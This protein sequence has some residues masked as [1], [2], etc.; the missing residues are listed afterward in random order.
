MGGAI[1]DEAKWRNATDTVKDAQ[2]AWL[3]L[4]PIG[5]PDID[6][7]ESRFR[8]GCRRVMDHVRRHNNLSKSTRS[9]TLAA[10]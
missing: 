4:P 2:A 1:N 10:V 9:G 3:R 6:L 5:G 7:L 8:D